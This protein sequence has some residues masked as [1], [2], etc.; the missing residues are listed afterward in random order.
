MSFLRFRVPDGLEGGSILVSLAVL[1]YR[2]YFH[3]PF[4]GMYYY[5]QLRFFRNVIKGKIVGASVWIYFGA[6]ISSS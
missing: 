5:F 3:A 6:R 4:D 1:T 2:D